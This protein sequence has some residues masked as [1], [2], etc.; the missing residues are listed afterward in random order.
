MNFLLSFFCKLTIAHSNTAILTFF[1]SLHR[2][3]KNHLFISLMSFL[4]CL[5]A[6]IL[7]TELAQ[8]ATK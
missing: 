4:T 5:E 3:I 6:F 1:L 8:Y 2:G 7:L